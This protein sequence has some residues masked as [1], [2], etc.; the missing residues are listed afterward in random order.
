LFLVCTKSVSLVK[1]GFLFATQIIFFAWTVAALIGLYVSIQKEL[2]GI[3]NMQIAGN[4]SS[5]FWLH[6]TQDRI[7][8]TMPHACFAPAAICFPYSY[9]LVGFVACSFPVEMA[10]VGLAMFQ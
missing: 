1:A 10:P 4:G 2:L 5:D 7:E 8:G 9:A 3:P 6:W